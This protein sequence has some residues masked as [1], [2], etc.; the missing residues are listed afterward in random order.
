L[1]DKGIGRPSTYA[2]IMGTIQDRGYV[3]KKG[4]ALVPTSDAFAVVNLLE[5]HF[6]DL[7]DYDFTARMEDDLDEIAGGRQ[8][9]EPWLNRFW[10]GN[11]VP[12]LKDSCQH[13]LDHADPAEVNTIPV[14]VDEAGEPIVVR[15]GRYGPYVKRGED[16]ASLPNDTALDELTIERAIELLNAPKGDEPIGTDPESGLPV[17]A[18]NG[19]HGPY[20]QLGDADT[21]PPKEKPK[22]ASLFKDMDLATIS[23]DDALRLLTLPRVVGADPADGVAI[24]ARNGP[25][26]PYLKK[27]ADTRNLE[28]EA[29]LLTVTLDEALALFAQP[30]AR[31]QR[32]AAAPPLRELGADPGSGKPIV[33]KDGRFG[34]YV[35]DGETNASLRKGDTVEEISMDRAL[36]LLQERRDRGP[37]KK[38][39]GRKAAGAKKTAVK[40]AATTKKATAKK[41]TAKKATGNKATGNKAPAKKAAV[42]VDPHA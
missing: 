7:V 34:P 26:G 6:S 24:E 31:R 5:G 13:A 36:E 12:G 37:V 29:A 32:G 18:K 3:W 33:V 15:N 9:R 10:F 4:Q 16:T 25:H 35:T 42:P 22:T 27:D 38:A 19:R 8:E 30:K 11:G 14:G 2:S 1:E 41:A 23:V 20:V 21:L 28:S 17:Y 40:K 39:G